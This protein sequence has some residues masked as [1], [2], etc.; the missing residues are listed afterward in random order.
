MDKVLAAVRDF[1]INFVLCSIPQKVSLVF[2]CYVMCCPWA[3]HCCVY[4]LSRVLA[5]IRRVRH[6]CS[7]DSRRLSLASSSEEVRLVSPTWTMLLLCLPSDTYMHIMAARTS[8]LIILKHSKREQGNKL[9]CQRLSSCFYVS[10]RILALSCL[11]CPS[12]PFG[13]SPNCCSQ[14]GECIP[15]PELPPFCSIKL[16]FVL[17]RGRHL[18]RIA[19]CGEIYNIRVRRYVVSRR[20]F[21]SSSRIFDPLFHLWT[22]GVGVST[23]FDRVFR[24]GKCDKIHTVYPALYYIYHKRHAFLFS[25]RRVHGVTLL[26]TRDTNTL[27]K[28][29]WL[30]KSIT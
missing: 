13:R 25:T 1:S 17:A 6:L 9:C 5:F 7:I 20:F 16:F 8:T 22:L 26:Q 30:L 4:G 24:V 29:S 12:S 3:I 11:C 14:N 18:S 19:R 10:F 15:D 21:A 2:S 27:E 28:M 23:P